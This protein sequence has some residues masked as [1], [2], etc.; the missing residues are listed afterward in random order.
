MKTIKRVH[1]CPSLR[2][3]DTVLYRQDHALNDQFIV[4]VDPGTPGFESSFTGLVAGVASTDV[5]QFW[6]SWIRLNT[7]TGEVAEVEHVEA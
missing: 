6:H 7:T 1:T 3:G 4:V 2:A 5:R